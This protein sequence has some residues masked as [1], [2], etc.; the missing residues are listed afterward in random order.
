MSDLSD[1]SNDTVEQKAANRRSQ[2][3]EAARRYHARR[4]PE[5]R[6]SHRQQECIRR[7]E[8]RQHSAASST[9][10][11][12]S[13]Q[14]SECVT[15]DVNE[16]DVRSAAW[17]DNGIPQ[18]R[19]VPLVTQESVL[20]RLRGALGASGLDET[21]DDSLR[22]REIPKFAITNA[23]ANTRCVLVSCRHGGANHYHPT[24]SNPQD[25]SCAADNDLRP[26]TVLS[27]PQLYAHVAVNCSQTA[28]DQVPVGS[29]VGGVSDNDA[30]AV[31]DEVVER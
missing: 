15:D 20:E 26:A 18:L 12:A 1:L 7:Q 27:R 3:A 16:L 5:D 11:S 19:T 29:R 9:S 17:G 14:R 13:R 23:D 28:E 2:N 21:C 30:T 4:T 25:A 8:R 31:Q 24:S 22:K 10:M 6:E